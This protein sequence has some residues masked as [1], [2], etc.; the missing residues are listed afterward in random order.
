MTED[1]LREIIDALMIIKEP[2]RTHINQLKREVATKY[3]LGKVPSNAEIIKHLKL[4]ERTK[5]LPIL[6]R[7]ATRSISGVTVIAV[8]TKPHHCPQ[9][10]PCA[11][12]PGGPPFG[13]PQSYTGY[14]PATL[15]G[16]ENEFDPYQ[17]VKNRIQQL[18]AIGHSSDKIELIIMGGTFPST[19]F[20]YQ[21]W[22]VQ[23]CLDAINDQDSA[24]LEEAIK[25]AEKSKLRNV[26]ITVETRPDWAKQV[27]VDQML[28]MGVTRV[29]L[30]VQNPDDEIYRL[31]GRT[32]TVAD[33]VKAT[34]TMKDSGLKITYHLMPGLPGSNKK[35]DLE[36]F[37]NIFS[38]PNFKPDMIKI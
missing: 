27:H 22:F 8:M 31:N 36:N 29:E 32:H 34:H 2:N 16:L 24:S 33:V 14:E 4:G 17:Q 5:L 6:R 1:A 10:N 35:K 23:R 28:S 7:K 15:R 38:D 21:E 3:H 9:P 20:N 19:P 12:C 26:G 13:V 37:Q 25:N 11:Y 30:G 18:Q